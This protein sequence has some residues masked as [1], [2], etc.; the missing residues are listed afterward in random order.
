M[1]T[2]NELLNRYMG[3]ERGKQLTIN[4]RA[5]IATATISP[6]P[7]Q[8]FRAYSESICPFENAKVVLLYD[9]P[10]AD[11][12]IADGLAFSS[13]KENHILHETKVLFNWMKKGCFPYIDAETFKSEYVNN[14]LY[15]WARQGV[16][17]INAKLCVY[18]G[19]P[20]SC[21]D[22]GWDEFTA[23]MIRQLS[24]V[25][26]KE[27]KPI[28][29]ISLGS[30]TNRF[31]ADVVGDIHLKIQ[32]E[33]PAFAIK[34]E[35]I[36]DT[37][38]NLFIGMSNFVVENYPEE[39]KMYSCS[40]EPAFNFEKVDELWLDYVVDNRIPMPAMPEGMGAEVRRSVINLANKLDCPGTAGI[41]LTPMINYKIGINFS[42]KLKE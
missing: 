30:K 34:G 1:T 12:A 6:V 13:K 8:S 19:R 11:P 33:N 16:L 4:Y 23:W 27:G 31:L 29:F 17:L 14:G 35:P 39:S 41:V 25:K 38:K 40:L 5:A 37:A 36:S 26:N 32:C 9:E 7:T 18:S 22:M 15:N 20:G 42:N 21:D 3:T 24:G 2:W 28:L 10:N